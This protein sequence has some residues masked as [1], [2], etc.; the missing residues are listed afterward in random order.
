MVREAAFVDRREAQLD[1]GQE[2]NDDGGHAPHEWTVAERD[3]DPEGAGQ[4]RGG[5]DERVEQR[6]GRVVAAELES[7]DVQCLEPVQRG[8]P[9]EHERR[10]REPAHRSFAR[11]AWRHERHAR[12]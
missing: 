6:R 7:H 10:G 2:Q 11:S 8:K 9:G 4:T 5:V 3:E 12:R 1:R